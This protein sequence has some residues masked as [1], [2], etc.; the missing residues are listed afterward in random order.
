MKKYNKDKNYC[1]HFT[2]HVG[3]CVWNKCCFF[4]DICYGKSG[5]SRLVCDKVFKRCVKRKKCFWAWFFAPIMYGFVRV[6]GAKYY[7]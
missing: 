7:K 6:F 3:K 4:H 5:I 1:T 2:G